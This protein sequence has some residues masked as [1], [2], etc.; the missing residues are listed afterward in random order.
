MKMHEFKK[1]L[2]TYKERN[3]VSN[4]TGGLKSKQKAHNKQELGPTAKHNG[5]K[6]RRP[7]RVGSPMGYGSWS[8]NR[9]RVMEHIFVFFFIFKP[10]SSF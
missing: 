6:G 9:E 2:T 5:L 8:S 3:A 10:T 7:K 1:L 4:Q